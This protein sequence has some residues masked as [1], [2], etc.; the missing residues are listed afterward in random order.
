V[1]FLCSTFFSNPGAAQEAMMRQQQQQGEKKRV[2]K[3]PQDEIDRLNKVWND[4][5]ITGTLYEVIS[6]GDFMTLREL[7]GGA[8][9]MAHIRSKDGRGPMWWAH[10]NGHSSIVKAL[11]R[12]GVSEELKDAKGMTPLDLST[13]VDV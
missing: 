12:L 2:A 10:E 8:P 3:L 1:R 9:E 7:L 4:N 13:I 5:E 11:K 6:S